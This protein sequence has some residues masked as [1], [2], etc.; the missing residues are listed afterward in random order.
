[1]KWL[2]LLFVACIAIRAQAPQPDGAGLIQGVFPAKWNTGGPDCAVLPPWQIHAYNS[3]FYILRESGCVHYEKPFVYFIFGERLA[4]LLDTGAGKPKTSEVVE[5]I[6]ADWCKSHGR[7][8]ESIE[9]VIAHTHSHDDHTAGDPD[10]VGKPHTQ[11]IPLTIKGTQ[12]FFHIPNWPQ[13]LGSIDLGDRIINV[14]PI[15]G[16]DPLSLAFYDSRTG[17]LLTGDTLY[18]GRLYIADFPEFVESIQ[19]LLDFTATRPVS[20]VLGNHIE[21]SSTPFLDYKVGTRYQPAEHELALTH[22]H[23]L[24]L[25]QGLAAVIINPVRMA[26]RDFTIWPK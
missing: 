9:L 3:D 14:I 11:M 10:F 5:R 26:F 7:A 23:L 8:R 21:Q 6:L 19:R 20:H 1:M 16:H 24:E 2:L 17:I 13:D 12:Q 25:R 4:L 22:A 15:P 18:P